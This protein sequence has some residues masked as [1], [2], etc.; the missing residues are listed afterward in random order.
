MN[1]RRSARAAAAAAVL[2]LAACAHAPAP[3]APPADFAVAG[4]A[5]GALRF[6]AYGDTRFTAP[7]ERTASIA[8]ARR[9]LVGAIAAE[10]PAA[11]FLTGDLPWHGG[12]PADYA[13]YRDET[14]AWRGRGLVVLPTLGNHEFQQCAERDCLENWWREFPALQGRRWY[15]VAL[16]RRILALAL[17]SDAP[18]VA[19][20][21]QGRWLDAT[22]ASL[23]RSVDFVLV[24]LHHPPVADLQTGSGASHNPRPNEQALAERLRLAAAAGRAR[25]LVCAGHIHN[26][27][28]READGIV[29]LVSGGGG[30]QPAEVVRDAQDRYRGPDFPNFH[31]LRFVLEGDALRGEML[32]LEDYG[33]DAPQHFERR[34]AFELKAAAR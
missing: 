4:P 3:S 27:E 9:A 24:F 8:P 7:A 29:Y 18:L 14:A 10:S 12:D 5:H 23:P 32:R 11:L 31:Y 22:L 15:S 33:A 6:I 20:S 1:G 30:A 17:D 25:F 2:A 16:G 26:Y 28:R 19:G 13:V 34:D 21:P